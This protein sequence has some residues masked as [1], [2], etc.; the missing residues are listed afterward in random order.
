LTRLRSPGARI[1]AYVVGAVLIGATLIAAS[2]VVSPLS[3]GRT[4]TV[5]TTN[6]ATRT[7]SATTVST[8][9]VTTDANESVITTTSTVTRTTTLEN[10]TTVSVTAAYVVATATFTENSQPVASCN[11]VAFGP[12]APPGYPVLLMRPNSTGYVCVTF[13]TFTPPAVQHLS[14]FPFPVG[15]RCTRVNATTSSCDGP[16]YDSFQNGVTPTNLTLPALNTT[17]FTVVYAYHALENSTGFYNLA[18][19]GPDCTDEPMAVG[20]QAAQVNAS[21]FDLPTLGPEC[22]AFSFL[23]V[24]EHV[25]GMNV[26]YI[27]AFGSAP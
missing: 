6:L 23:P 12:G 16:V 4:M 21:D 19:F 24:S 5:T 26:T 14:F 25:T 20:Y 22:P 27:D 13:E 1:T 15:Q 3:Q 9:T 8:T 18:A 17:F 10:G 7:L 2:L 11:T